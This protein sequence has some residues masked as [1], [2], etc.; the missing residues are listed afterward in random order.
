MSKLLLFLKIKVRT[1]IPG[2]CN[3][4]HSKI[5]RENRFFRGNENGN[6]LL[7]IVGAPEAEAMAK[8]IKVVPFGM[9][10]LH[11]IDPC[12]LLPG[13]LVHRLCSVNIL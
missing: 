7:G 3:E 10:L 12:L 8:T 6:L 9:R 11:E 5:S 4:Q 1:D 2:C 13:N